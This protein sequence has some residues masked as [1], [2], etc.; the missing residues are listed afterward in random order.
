MVTARAL[1][2]ALLGAWLV[3]CGTAAM[4]SE[5]AAESDPLAAG[6]ASPAPCET[7]AD[8]AGKPFRPNALMCMKGAG[9]ALQ[10]RAH[11]CVQTCVPFAADGGAP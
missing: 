4:K 7:V 3:A 10:C 8:C 11:E 9:V 2:V 1:G 6:G 5:G